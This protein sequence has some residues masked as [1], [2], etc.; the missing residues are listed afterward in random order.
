M[1]EVTVKINKAALG[2]FLNKQVQPF[3]AK[4]AREVVAEA[5]KSAPNATGELQ[6]SMSVKNGP[7]G[8][9]EIIVNAPHAG[10]VHSGT[11]PQHQPTPRPP[12]FPK[13]RRRG[14][15]LWSESKGANPYQVAAGIAKNGTPANPFLSDSLEKVLGRYQYKWI[16]RDISAG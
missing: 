5:M 15:I 14:L 16:S 6:S 3:L 11:G 2:R 8:S 13:V 12:Y 10:F 4:K 7:R 9:V 1:A